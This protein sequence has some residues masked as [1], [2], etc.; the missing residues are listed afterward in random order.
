MSNPVET[1]RVDNSVLR[2]N[3]VFTIGLLLL[4]FVLDAPWLA[5]FVAVINLIAALFPPLGL[6][7]G[8]YNAVLKP[9]G[10]IK[11]DVVTD[12]PEPH[13]F[14][15]GLGAVFV[16]LGALAYYAGATTLGWALVWLVI[17]LAATNLFLHFCVGCFMYYQ[18]NRLGVPGFR[19]RP[20]ERGW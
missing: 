17:G 9:A 3:M 5:A 14:A 13:R 12:N 4:A 15:Q 1:R 20:V 18:L 6:W 11:P 8:V 2:V 7:R 16:G 19:Y 10:I